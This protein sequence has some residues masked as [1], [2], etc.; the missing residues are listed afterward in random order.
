MGVFVGCVAILGDVRRPAKG[1]C[2]QAR[3]RN[4]FGVGLIDSDLS[5]RTEGALADFRS[6]WAV[7]ILDSATVANT[8]KMVAGASSR[9]AKRE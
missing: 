4:R 7:A 3:E 1:A 2:G 9:G 6:N 5:A 8:G